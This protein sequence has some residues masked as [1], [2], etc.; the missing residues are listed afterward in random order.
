MRGWKRGWI[1]E[2]L[3]PV[4]RWTDF[5]VAHRGRVLAVWLVLFVLGGLGAANLGGL[6]TN[7]FS[8]PGSESERGLELLEDRMGDRADGAFTLVAEGVESEAERAA[9]EAA[10]ARAAAEAEDGKASPPHDAGR[11]RRLRP[12][13]DAA[14]EP[15]RVPG[16][17]GDARRDRRRRGR[18]RPTCPATPRS[19][20]TP[21]TS[22]TRTSRAAS[23]S[24]CRSRCS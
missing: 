10:A 14:G 3:A 13:L 20:T 9:V 2:I 11:R 6:L 5:V 21:R 23:R 8:V 22:S 19:T 1:R 12:D 16:H 4:A 15:G 24:R 7:R 18:A 17:G